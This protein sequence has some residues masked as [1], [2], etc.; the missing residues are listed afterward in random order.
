M[1]TIKL[2]Q[3]SNA[4]DHAEMLRNSTDAEVSI[5]FSRGTI[6]VPRETAMTILES[7]PFMLIHAYASGVN[8]EYSPTYLKKNA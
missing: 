5:E 4:F 3:E 7:L 6:I 8:G 1:L 2:T